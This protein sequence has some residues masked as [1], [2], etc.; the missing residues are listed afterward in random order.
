LRTRHCSDR[1]ISL[2]RSKDCLLPAVAGSAP[3]YLGGD[4]AAAA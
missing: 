2:S 3:P 1:C 4:F